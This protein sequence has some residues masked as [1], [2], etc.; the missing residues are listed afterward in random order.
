M[1]FD[2]ERDVP[3]KSFINADV[4]ERDVRIDPNDLDN[5]MIRHPSLMVHYSVQT[6]KAKKQLDS[7]KNLLEILIAQMDG[8]YRNMV[9]ENGKRIFTTETAIKNAVIKDQR[10]LLMNIKLRKAQEEF[11]LCEIAENAFSQ[12]KDLILEIARDRRKEKEGQMRVLEQQALRDNV[13]QFL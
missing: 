4:M 10:Y 5:E 12:R 8:E 9:D 7:V 3:V 1:N 13:K 6:V 2:I 11:K